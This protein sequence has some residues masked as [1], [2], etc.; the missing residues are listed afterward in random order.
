M[1]EHANALALA[2]AESIQ[3]D[4]PSPDGIISVADTEEARPGGI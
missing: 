2:L 4:W 3:F 1:T